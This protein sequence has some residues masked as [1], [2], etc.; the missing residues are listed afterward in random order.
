MSCGVACGWQSGLTVP[1]VHPLCVVCGA[2][3]VSSLITHISDPDHA[4]VI[5]FR[6]DGNV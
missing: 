2:A 1:K 3:L 6:H 4:A 5:E